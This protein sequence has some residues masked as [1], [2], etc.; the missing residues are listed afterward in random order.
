MPFFRSSEFLHL[1]D[2][3]RF[4][5]LLIALV[6]LIIALVV[7]TEENEET[8]ELFILWPF[9]VIWMSR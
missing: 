3:M 2:L 4:A 7:E 8:T 5:F 9:T 6:F 1:F